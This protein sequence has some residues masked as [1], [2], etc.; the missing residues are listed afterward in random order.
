MTT[1]ET[2]VE[3]RSGR[4]RCRPRPCAG[5]GGSRRRAFVRPVRRVRLLLDEVMR[6]HQPTRA[7]LERRTAEG[8]S[9]SRIVGELFQTGRVQFYGGQIR[10]VARQGQ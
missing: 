2:A 4:D 7:Y 5:S 1:N 9:A 8:R 3:R 6:H 10:R